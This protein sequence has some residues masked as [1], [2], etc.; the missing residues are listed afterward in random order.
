MTFRGDVLGVVITD[1][2]GGGADTLGLWFNLPGCAPPPFT[3]F[4]QSLVGRAIVVDAPPL[5]TFKDQCRNG[6]WAPFGFADQGQCIR[7]V[8]PPAS[9]GLR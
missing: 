2:G 9:P 8:N 5:P 4:T 3:P 6:G 7:L 1:N